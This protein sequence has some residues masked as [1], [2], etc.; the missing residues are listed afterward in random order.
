MIAMV[1]RSGDVAQTRAADARSLPARAG[2]HASPTASEVEAELSGN[3]HRRAVFILSDIRRQAS[4]IQI[5]FGAF[6]KFA[7]RTRTGLIGQ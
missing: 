6:E 5:V 4:L 3:A 2:T 7:R 1:R